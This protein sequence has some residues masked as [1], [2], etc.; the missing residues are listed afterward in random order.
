VEYQV[1]LGADQDKGFKLDAGIKG[2]FA[3][4][5]ASIGIESHRAFAATQS[6]SGQVS[7]RLSGEL[8]RVEEF[9]KVDD[10]RLYLTTHRIVFAGRHRTIEVLLKDLVSIQGTPRTLN[11]RW[12]GQSRQ[13]QFQTVDGDLIA[14]LVLSLRDHR[15]EEKATLTAKADTS[16][17]RVER[18]CPWCA[19]PILAKALVCKH[20][21]RD[22][23][24]VD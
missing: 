7:A 11:I 6:S 15:V 5:G 10:G 24:G 21:G 12:S 23:V 20:C 3:S 17:N 14:Q 4:G 8:V 1:V 2:G 16:M 13:E 19:E 9:E 18:E 22:V